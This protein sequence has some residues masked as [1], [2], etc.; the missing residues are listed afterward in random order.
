MFSN[1]CAKRGCI[2][3]SAIGG[4]KKISLN[5]YLSLFIFIFLYL[6]LSIFLFFITITGQNKLHGQA[7]GSSCKSK[8]PQSLVT[9]WSASYKKVP[10]FGLVSCFVC[11]RVGGLVCLL[12]LLKIFALHSYYGSIKHVK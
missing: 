12:F 9:F 8:R 1:D 7:N 3:E 5:V 11:L 10:T 6:S 4:Q 2:T